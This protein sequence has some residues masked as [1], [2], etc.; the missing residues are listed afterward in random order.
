MQDLIF[1]IIMYAFF[2]GFIGMICYQ[3]AK[4]NLRYLQQR[5][6][7][8]QELDIYQNF[9]FKVRRFLELTIGRGSLIAAYSFIT[10]MTTIFLV[11]F[12]GLILNGYGFVVSF[13]LPTVI[14]GSI[15]YLFVLLG[16]KNRVL[17][18]HEGIVLVQ[19]LLS[20]YKIYN[21]NIYEAIEQTANTLSVEQAPLSKKMMKNLSY[22][23]RQARN[24]KQVKEALNQMFY[25]MDVSWAYSLSI[26]IEKAVIDGIDIEDSLKD[27]FRDLEEL[28]RLKQDLKDEIHETKVMLKYLT[29]F[30]F[31]LTIYLFTVTFG[32]T[33]FQYFSYQL[34]KGFIYLIITSILY[35]VSIGLYL[36]VTKPKND[37]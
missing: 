13:L 32:F 19:E 24:D 1:R 14:I 30:M 6:E 31:A 11:T 29:P 12:T 17:I 23:L 35:L 21:R 26:V 18:T 8:I 7:R 36:Y 3:L 20:N 10:L 16:Y 25:V 33:I 34:G 5:Y 9:I 27:I 15:Y 2:F 4:P 22:R 28:E 37:F